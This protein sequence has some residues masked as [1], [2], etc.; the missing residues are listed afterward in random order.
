MSLERRSTNRREESQNL[1]R[2]LPIDRARAASQYSDLFSSKPLSQSNNVQWWGGGARRRGWSRRGP[3]SREAHTVRC[4]PT[5]PALRFA[6]V[7]SSSSSSRAYPVPK[8]WYACS[9]VWGTEQAPAC[10]ATGTEAYLG[11][12]GSSSPMLVG[13]REGGG[14][15]GRE[16]EGERGSAPPPRRCRRRRLASRSARRRGGAAP[17][18][19]A[20]P[21][22]ARGACSSS[23]RRRRTWGALYCGCGCGCEGGG[24]GEGGCGYEGGGGDEGISTCR[25]IIDRSLEGNK[26]GGLGS[27]TE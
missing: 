5:K 7:H 17:R 15:R 6:A 27:D 12:S 8:V 21:S 14:G 25:P 1:S 22:R 2:T 19:S 10:Q 16:G 23:A 9:V 24:G 4:A 20:A 26:P 11:G 3:T 18:R 13:S